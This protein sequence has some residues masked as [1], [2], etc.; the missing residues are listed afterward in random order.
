MRSSTY[1][2]ARYATFPLLTGPERE[3][4]EEVFAE[5]E[6]LLA[7]LLLIAIGDPEQPAHQSFKMWRAG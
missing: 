5:L 1:P 2:L 4:D 6:R 3:A 7:D